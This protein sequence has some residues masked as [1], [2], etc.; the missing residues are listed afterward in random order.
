MKNIT[1]RTISGPLVLISLI[2]EDG[3]E[4][5]YM[6]SMIEPFS[7]SAQGVGNFR[8]TLKNPP[9]ETVDLAFSFVDPED[10]PEDLADVRRPL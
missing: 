6:T 8:A 7:L 9:F 4:V 2:G 5:G 3:E 1:G 10:A